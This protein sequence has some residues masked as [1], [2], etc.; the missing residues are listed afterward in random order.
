MQIEH[1][2]VKISA[3]GDTFIISVVELFPPCISN[4]YWSNLVV[5]YEEFVFMQE[6]FILN[7]ILL[8]R[9]QREHESNSA[10]SINNRNKIH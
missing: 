4:Y 10:R 9:L 7:K 6:Y 2:F 1:I 8:L 5:A 3:S